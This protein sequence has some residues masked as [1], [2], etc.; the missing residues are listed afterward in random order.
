MDPSNLLRDH[1][2]LTTL[3]NY[4]TTLTNETLTHLHKT[5]NKTMTRIQ[6]TTISLISGLEIS[7]SE[8]ANH[9]LDGL[10]YGLAG[11]NGTCFSNYFRYY[12]NHHELLSICCADR[13]NPYNKVNHLLTFWSKSSLSFL[14]VTIFVYF[15]YKSIYEFLIILMIMSPY[16][17]FI[18]SLA[19][20][21]I[22]YR[23][24]YCIKCCGH[25]G[26][27]FLILFSVINILAMILGIYI[28]IQTKPNASHIITQFLLSI[29]FDQLQPLYLGIFN[30]ILHSWEGF[31][32]L[33]QVSCCGSSPCPPRYY[34]LLGIFPIKLI[35]ES[36]SLGKEIV[37]DLLLSL[38][39]FV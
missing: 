12:S 36:Y 20:C 21:A 30:W 16:G 29:L 38:P 34:P 25:I 10:K 32:C 14:L 23:Y 28:L 31:L 15:H 24:N 8:I 3:K 4:T 26:F 22:C 17:Y 18:D 33:P 7:E 9:Y 27:F 19:T 1:P 39:H 6:D 11:S 2:H 37:H 35:L 5:T 13:R